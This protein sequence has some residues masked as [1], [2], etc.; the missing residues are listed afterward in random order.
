MGSDSEFDA[1]VAGFVAG[2]LG[3][4]ID[5]VHSFEQAANA[6]ARLE[7]GQQFGKVVVRIS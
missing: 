7:S 1:I 2:R 4:T 6:M 5:S 3:V